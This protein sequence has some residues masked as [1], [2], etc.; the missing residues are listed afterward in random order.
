MDRVTVEQ[1]SHVLGIKEESV[2]KRVSRGKLRS[3]KDEDGW[4]LVYVDDTGMFRDGSEDRS[5]TDEEERPDLAGELIEEMRD[6][7]RSLEKPTGRGEGVEEAGRHHPRA[8]HPGQRRPRRSRPR[9]RDAARATR[10]PPECYGRATRARRRPDPR[11]SGGAQEPSA[12]QEDRRS[13]WRTFFGF[14]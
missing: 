14:E 4:L 10:S 2:R 11:C 8:A 5:A 6:R 3:E 13:W 7:V 12:L 1:A 9:R